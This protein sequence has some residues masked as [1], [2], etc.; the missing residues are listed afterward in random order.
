MVL[1]E[2]L[3]D[4]PAS[5][6]WNALTDK[7]EMKVWYFDLENFIPEKG[8]QFSFKG[9]PSPEKQYTHLCE[10]TE[11][12]HQ[13]RLVYSWRYDGYPG[14]SHVSFELH[15]RGEK[16]LLRL[17]HSGLDSFGDNPDFA[18]RNFAEGWDDI[19]HRSLKAYLA[20]VETT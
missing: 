13:Q 4:A 11:V 20:N 17:K 1:I 9:G 8:F 10:I 12:V 5:R 2:E 3:F 14:I 6:V 15:M 19:I 16:T 18:V 7:D